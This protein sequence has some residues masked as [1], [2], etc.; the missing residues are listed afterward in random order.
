MA[1]PSA[2]SW[3]LVVPMESP[4]W[5]ALLSGRRTVVRDPAGHRTSSRWSVAK[6]R[7]LQVVRHPISGPYGARPY[8]GPYL[9]GL[10]WAR[11][12][13]RSMSAIEA[14]RVTVTPRLSCRC[15]SWR[16]AATSVPGG[17]AREAARRAYASWLRRGV[18]RILSPQR[19]R[20][21]AE[22]R[23]RSPPCARA[24]HGRSSVL[25]GAYDRPSS[26]RSV[27]RSTVACTSSPARARRTRR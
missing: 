5:G 17:L 27:A 12:G 16:R 8:R 9:L 11:S 3:P 19:R 20:M 1:S 24:R 4:R 23:P 21:S 6:S 14:W 15:L 25:A 26:A 22:H 2:R 10:P 18:A 13:T 7:S